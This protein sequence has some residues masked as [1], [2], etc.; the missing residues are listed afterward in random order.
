MPAH[1]APPVI[2]VVF[3]VG[4]L[5]I[6]TLLSYLYSRRNPTRV[7]GMGR[8]G[9]QAQQLQPPTYPYMQ[10]PVGPYAD[11]V[12]HW[13]FKSSARWIGVWIGI[14]VGIGALQAPI[15]AV[16][17]N[18]E[19]Q[20]PI[21]PALALGAVSALLILYSLWRPTGA[22]Q[23]C[24]V[25]Q[26]LYITLIR[27]GR[28]IPLDL[29]HYRWVRMHITTARYG[30]TFPSM[31]VFDRDSRPGMFTLLSSMLFP[32]FDEGRIVLFYNKWLT[33]DGA[34]IPYTVVDDFFRDACRRAG[35]H[36]QFKEPMFAV[37]PGRW[38]VRPD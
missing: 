33:A 10:Q 19:L 28:G 5:G 29:N 22:A 17:G 3:L 13:H 30:S 31:L 16:A 4:F 26:N 12:G 11:L 32:R 37:G 21:L 36:P 38:E 27:R 2:S 15:L 18:P 7:A 25:D 35:R 1:I 23:E 9:Q 34:M 24:H 14:I 6:G 8:Y 20:M